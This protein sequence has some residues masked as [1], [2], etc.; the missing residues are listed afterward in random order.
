MDTSE[1]PGPY[2][3]TAVAGAALATL[4]FP[5]IALLRTWACAS[6]GWM[7]FGALFAI[8]LSSVAFR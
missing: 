1:G 2:N 3:G 6:G 7:L 4:F 8:V 5:L